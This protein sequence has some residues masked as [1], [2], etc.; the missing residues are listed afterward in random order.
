MV[1]LFILDLDGTLI[2][3]F[4]GHL[5][6]YN[7][8][9]E[10]SGYDI[11]SAGEFKKYYGQTGREIMRQLMEKEKIDEEV[12]EVFK[13]KKKIYRAANGA[14]V[15]I[16]PGAVELI[17]AICERHIPISIASSAGR[18]Y[19]EIALKI[20]G[21]QDKISYITSSEDITHSKPNPEIFLKAAKKAGILA[22]DCLVIEDS[23]HGIRAAKSAD[24]KCA[25]VIGTET[26][27]TL[28]KEEP[29]II[30]DSLKELLPPRLDEI[31]ESF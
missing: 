27:R 13:L 19:I 18:S 5:I 3:A 14:Y 29:N 1:R 28:K 26:K 6:S 22:K 30:T 9:L 4:D 12:E 24:M 2:D 10:T 20:M 23:I 17:D 31:I 21:V 15:K 16:L 25:A 8:A 11:V 7:G